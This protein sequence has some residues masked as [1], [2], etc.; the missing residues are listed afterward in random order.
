MTTKVG[1]LMVPNGKYIS[2]GEE[3]TRWLKCGALFINDRGQH[4]LKLDA[5]PINFHET[6]G[7]FSVF[8]ERGRGGQAQP[9]ARPAPAPAPPADNPFEDDD[10]PF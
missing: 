7:W 4:R 2:D 6:G 3:K 1:D 10:V 8:E 5:I 9:A